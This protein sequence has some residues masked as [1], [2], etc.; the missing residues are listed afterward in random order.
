MYLALI[1]RNSFYSIIFDNQYLIELYF[2]HLSIAACIKNG[3]SI[4]KQGGGD[5]LEKAKQADVRNG[6]DENNSN[7]LNQMT[8]GGITNGHV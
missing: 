6:Q 8:T 1:S 5:N 7:V 3:K 2:F 4:P